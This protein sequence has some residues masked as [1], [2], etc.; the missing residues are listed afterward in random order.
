M[1]NNYFRFKQFTVHQDK[2]AMKVCTDACLFGAWVAA[3]R[4]PL[5][6]YNSPLT[7]HYLLDIGAGTGLLA[8][9]YAQ[10]D[11]NTIIDAVEIDEVAA[12]QAKENFGAS[13]WKER[14]YAYK[15]SIQDFSVTT[16]K[17]YDKVICNPPFYESDLKS[18]NAK[19]NVALHSSE[20]KLNE[21]I[22][23]AKRLLNE[24]GSFFVLLPFYRSE[25]FGQLITGK[26]FIKEKVLIKQ[27]PGH[28]YFRT[29]FW[30]TRQPANEH[31]SEITIMTERN[32]YS[33][34]FKELLKDY[35]PALQ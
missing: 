23:I 3:N 33:V 22:E 5:P 12:Q 28:N 24:D 17:N 8:L 16:D 1:P 15:N 20:L 14:L 7:A 31:Q 30:L 6:V 27:T 9:M 21:L 26:F 25:E 19:R 2:C 13:P 4:P 35:Y 34:A 10:K 11:I 18:N 29:M 32:E